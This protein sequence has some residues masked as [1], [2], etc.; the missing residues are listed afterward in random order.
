[1]R[2]LLYYSTFFLVYLGISVKFENNDKQQYYSRVQLNKKETVPISGKSSLS[3]KQSELLCNLPTRDFFKQNRFYLSKFCFYLTPKNKLNKIPHLAREKKYEEIINLLKGKTDHFSVYWRLKALLKLKKWNKL[4][5]QIP[6]AKKKLP[7]LSDYLTLLAAQA[8]LAENNFEN[9]IILSKII[10]KTERSILGI[11]NL[12][13]IFKKQNKLNEELKYVEILLSNNKLK[14]SAKAELHL[15]AAFIKKKLGKKNKIIIQHLLWV[16]INKPGSPLSRKAHQ[17]SKKWYKK[18]ISIFASYLDKTRRAEFLSK[19]YLNRKVLRT[20]RYP[21]KCKL[22][23][24]CKINYLKGRALFYLKKRRKAAR[25]LAKSIYKCEKTKLNKYRVKAKYLGGKNALFRAHYKTAFSL[26]KRAYLEHPNDSYA[27]DAMLK[28]SKALFGLKKN[29][30]ANKIL[31]TATKKYP[32]GDMHNKILWNKVLPQ[33]TSGKWKAVE[34][35]LADIRKSSVPEPPLN[36]WGRIIYWQGRVAMIQNKTKKAAKFFRQTVATAPVTYYAAQALNRMEE[37]QKGSGKR[38]LK[39]ILKQ[40]KSNSPHPFPVLKSNI[41]KKRLFKQMVEFARLQDRK[42]LLETYKLLNLKLPKSKSKI[43]NKA[44]WKAVSFILEKGK[45]KHLAFKIM[46]KVLYLHSSSWPTDFNL[47]L[48]KIAYPKLYQNKISKAAATYK[49]QPNLLAGLVREESGFSPK[50]RSSAGAMG[51]AQIMPSTAK[52]LAR[53]AKLKYKSRNQLQNSQLNL[54]LAAFYLKRLEKLF[55]GKIILQVGAYNAGEGA[56]M[57]RYKKFKG[58]LD[59]FVE[60]LTI[61]ETRNYI[62]R[63][64]SSYFAYTILEGKK[65][66]PSLPLN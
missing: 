59:L 34:K 51:L 22:A 58:Q 45:A 41:F 61:S 50:V 12:I 28:A 44:L 31:E 6:H 57:K 16:W 20:L 30:K 42:N 66:F 48:W 46:G 33:L 60:A 21:G 27:D 18:G 14:D 63:V 15:R 9:S 8:N 1:M 55:K 54:K 13:K 62:K 10:M 32:K 53:L 4:L 26:F 17:L 49:I 64:I 5:Q 19:F 52:Y 23:Q 35:I 2:L 56:I 65:T 39:K 38:F 47:E 11:K 40:Q 43:K 29:S 3:G 7:L 37:I 36:N 24:E 25:F